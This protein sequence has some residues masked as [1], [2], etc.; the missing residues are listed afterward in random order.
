MGTVHHMD[1][2]MLNL[3]A[4]LATIPS[5]PRPI[6]DR[7]VARMIDRLDEMDGDDDLEDGRDREE[8]YEGEREHQ[9]I[10]RYT[11]DQRLLLGEYGHRSGL[12]VNV[13]T[14]ASQRV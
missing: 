8:D 6:L 9:L 12:A 14:G 2:A 7:L 13:D 10:P 4:M 5:L 3:G 1:P 11:T